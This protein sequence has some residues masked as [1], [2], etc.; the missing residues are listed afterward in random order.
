MD[1]AT[2]DLPRGTHAAVLSGRD[3]V[4]GERL[5]YPVVWADRPYD[6]CPGCGQPVNRVVE[7]CPVVLNP[8]AA[9]GGRIEEWDKQHGCGQWLSVAWQR[10]GGRSG[11]TTEQDILDAAGQL[12]DV[13]AEQVDAAYTR[14]KARLSADLAEALERLAGPLRDGETHDERVEQ[15]RTGSQIEPGIDIDQGTWLAWDYHPDG[16][17]D[18]VTVTD[19]DLTEARR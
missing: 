4:T 18:V 7:R 1:F 16:S 8:G 19:A 10:V 9:Q 5:A 17:G 2:L 14:L 6:T 11:E 12:A 13:L 3:V 15:L